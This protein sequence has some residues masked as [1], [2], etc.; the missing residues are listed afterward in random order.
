MF[1]VGVMPQSVGYLVLVDVGG[2]DGDVAKVSVG[3]RV[4]EAIADDE[5]VRDIESE[6]RDI[7]VDLGGTWL[8]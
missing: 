1:A 7:H 5:L 6:V 8:S 2:E 3:I 4:I